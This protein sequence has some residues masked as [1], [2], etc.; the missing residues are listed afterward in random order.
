M[1]PK[2]K[3]YGLPPVEVETLAHVKSDEMMLYQYLPIRVPGPV[4]YSLSESRLKFLD[5]IVHE[6]TSDFVKVYGHANWA[7]SYCYLTVKNMFAVPGNNLNRHGWH[8]DGFMSDDISYIM[9]DCYPTEWLDFPTGM[10]QCHT[11][12]IDRFNKLADSFPRHIHKCK[13]NVLYRMDESV[14]H[15]VAED[16][17]EPRMRLFIKINFS[18]NVYNLKGNT[19]NYNLVYDWGTVERDL[20]RNHPTK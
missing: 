11:E 9:S 1:T 20:D 18:K 13:A 16:F 3:I 7:D 5:G 8:S 15:R 19:K 2:P 14:I 10:V 17:T 6:A 4:G 12:S